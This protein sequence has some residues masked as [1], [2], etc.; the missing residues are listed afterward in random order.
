MANNEFNREDM[1]EFIIGHEIEIFW[2]F[3]FAFFF[4]VLIEIIFKPFRSWREQIK[5]VKALYSFI[6]KSSSLRPEDLLGKRPFNP[7]YY[8]RQEDDLI[9]K[10]LNDK[11]NLLII[12]SP[13]SGKSRAL[14][15]ALNYLKEP[16]KVAITICKDINPETFQL[17]KNTEIIVIDDLH[18]FVE[19]QNFDRLFRIALKNNT[20]IAATCRSEIE[21]KKVENKML[22]KNI[23]LETIFGENIIKL[24]RISK[25]VGKEIAT[26]ADIRWGDVEFDGTVGSIFMRLE[27]MK[28]RFDN[29]ND[30]EKTI[31]RAIK[32][33]HICGIY[34][35]NLFSLEWI[36]IAAKGVGLEGKDYEWTDWFEN[37]KHKEFIALEKNKVQAEEVYLE[38]VVKLPVEI[39]ILD[40]LEETITIFSGIPEAL[41]R[42]A[43]RAFGIGTISLEKAEYMKISIQACEEALK[44]ATL[45]RFPME[46]ATTQNNLGN[47][48]STLAGVEAKAENC[49]RAIQ[50]YEEALK[51]YTLGRFPMDYAGTQNNLGSAY[52]IL[53]EVEAKAEN[54][55][56]AIQA[57]EEALKVRTLGRFPMQY[58]NTQNSLGNAYST[59]AGVEAKAENCRRAIQAYEEALKVVSRK[60]FPKIYPLVKQ[61]LRK[62]LNFCRGE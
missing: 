31:L 16:K 5:K 26:K 55:K 1:K 23:G 28:R 38:V 18:R 51:V 44:V 41:F 6:G 53:A 21:C 62:L 40:V 45:D 8:R 17:A 13:L 47:A 14:F 58:A 54:C 7:Y 60:E 61:N 3:L 9:G 50:A 57:Y 35:E 10:S 48:Y 46:Y 30:I 2:A 56:K 36:K 42:L 12:G 37:L 33:L 29:C 11:K 25:E 43:N 15:Q 39:K 49:R 32:T 19:Q 34:E 22:D 24:P 59:L 52:G 4:A 20:V 27:E